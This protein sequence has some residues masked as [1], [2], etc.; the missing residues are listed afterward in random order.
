MTLIEQRGVERDYGFAGIE[1]IIDE[2]THGRLYIAD[3][4]GGESTLDGGAV[5]WRHG[6]AVALHPD[7]TMAALDAESDA[8]TRASIRAQMLAGYDDSRP[9]IPNANIEALARAVGI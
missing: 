2:P 6:V 4:Y 8:A 9:I 1:A 5:R 7:D 3:G